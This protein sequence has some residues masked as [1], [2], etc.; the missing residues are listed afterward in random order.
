MRRSKKDDW[1]LAVRIAV[2]STLCMEMATCPWIA[3]AVDFAAWQ[4]IASR[5]ANEPNAMQVD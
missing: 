2:E 4:A 1:E 5:Q 3:D